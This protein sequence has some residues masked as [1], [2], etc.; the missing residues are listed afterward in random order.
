MVATRNIR[1]IFLVTMLGACVSPDPY[2]DLPPLDLEKI[3]K[4]LNCPSSTTP[5]CQ[6]RQGQT[7]RCYCADRDSLREILE[8]ET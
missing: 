5:V 7:V 3:M 1:I 6:Q 8:R 2:A 4:S